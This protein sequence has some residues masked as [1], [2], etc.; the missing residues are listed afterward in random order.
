M[1]QI[2]INPENG[3]QQIDNKL[4]YKDMKTIY[5]ILGTVF[6]FLLCVGGGIYLPDVEVVINWTSSIQIV[7]I[8]Y[9]SPAAFYGLAR[10]KYPQNIDKEQD[11]YLLCQSY[12][13]YCLA[14]V[15]FLLGMT[16]NVLAIV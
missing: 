14:V 12:M 8:G 6:Y 2:K 4:A 5:Y 10:K 1:P 7:I 16:V 11:N 15:T 13:Q 3:E 9:L